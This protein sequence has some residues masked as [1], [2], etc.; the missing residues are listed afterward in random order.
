MTNAP[1]SFTSYIKIDSPI[2]RNPP[3][4]KLQNSRE[5]PALRKPLLD[6]VV[7]AG[8]GLGEI[9]GENWAVVFSPQTVVGDDGILL[10]TLAVEDPLGV[11]PCFAADEEEDRRDEYNSP[12]LKKESVTRLKRPSPE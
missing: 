6:I 11:L 10:C 4:K 5:S 9:A 2:K 3:A 12:F 7:R 1:F 8:T